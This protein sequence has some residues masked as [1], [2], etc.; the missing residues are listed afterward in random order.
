VFEVASG[1]KPPV[2]EWRSLGWAVLDAHD[3]SRTA[4]TYRDY[5]QASRGEFSVAKNVYVATRS[6]WFSGRS[7]CYLAAGRPVVVQDTG[8]AKVIPCG[9][10]LLA[11]TSLDE[12]VEAVECVEQ[13]YRRHQEAARAVAAEFFEAG[14][15]IGRLL[16][17]VGLGK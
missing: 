5:I 2:D 11:F 8:F 15:V 7:T 12:A 6:G 4:D 13:D 17:E 16:R 3:V 1:G 14:R 10:G 9:S